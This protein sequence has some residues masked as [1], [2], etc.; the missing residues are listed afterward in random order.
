[1]PRPSRP[2]YVDDSRLSV[3]QPAQRLRAHLR[4]FRGPVA[5]GVSEVLP[6]G[7]RRGVSITLDDPVNQTLMRLRDL[8]PPWWCIANAIGHAVLD[9]FERVKEDGQDRR[10]QRPADRGMEDV[11]LPR[12]VR[13]VRGVVEHRVD[14][15]LENAE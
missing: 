10:L 11:V 15:G 12:E 1:M 4:E 14:T 3:A 7:L 2:A 9:V 8:Q 6:H 5:L 13:L